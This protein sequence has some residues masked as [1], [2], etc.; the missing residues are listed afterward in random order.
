[1]FFL[2]SYRAQRGYELLSILN[3]TIF[4]EAI[5]AISFILKPTLQ[6]RISR[7]FLIRQLTIITDWC[8]ALDSYY[9]PYIHTPARRNVNSTKWT[10]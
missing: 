4:P 8:S 6:S 1:M 2:A 9:I 10:S 7:Y 3:A 5:I